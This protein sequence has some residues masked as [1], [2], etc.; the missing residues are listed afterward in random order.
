[1]V[2]RFGVKKVN[3]NKKRSSIHERKMKELKKK[4][5]RPIK[6]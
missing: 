3:K 5:M 4:K 6:L 1:M 2:S